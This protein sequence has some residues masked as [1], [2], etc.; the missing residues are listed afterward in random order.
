M[1]PRDLW[2]AWRGLLVW[3]VVFPP[4]GAITLDVTSQRESAVPF[5]GGI[6]RRLSVPANSKISL[7]ESLKDAA[8]TTVYAMMTYYHGNETGQIP[9]AFPTK[10]WE[11]SA[12]FMALLQYWYYT[13]DSTYNN[14]L[15]AGLE[16]QSGSQGNYMPSNY[17]AYLVSVW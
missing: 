8:S 6:G 5:L 10:W 15:S 4:A 7:L 14:E 17:S 3:L 11:G 9:G 12:L 16:W 1:R 13:G 2:P